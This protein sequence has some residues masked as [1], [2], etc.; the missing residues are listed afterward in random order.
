MKVFRLFTYAGA[1]TGVLL[2][3]AGTGAAGATML[4]KTAPGGFTCPEHYGAGTTIEATFTSGST[5]I[6]ETAE[7]TVLQTCAES[8]IKGKTQNTGSSTET[9]K[10]ALESWT[11]GKCTRT[12]NTLK[13]GSL[14]LH[15]HTAYGGPLTGTGS[16]EWTTNTIFG[17]C[18]Y[19][20]GTGLNLG[21][22]SG[23]NPAT[24]SVNTAV[25]K[26]SG[27]FACPSTTL[28]TANYTITTPEP[29]YVV[30]F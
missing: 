22:L 19:G 25:P 10:V 24:I 21:T 7:G 28:W 13:L 20:T 11:W 9:I 27:N 5:S 6:F 3:I 17:S 8:T 26:I 18:V 16:T 4:C 2:A 29:L 1:L 14:E 30:P 15:Y 23:G 12:M